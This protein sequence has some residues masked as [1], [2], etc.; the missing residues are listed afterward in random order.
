MLG[1]KG[2]KSSL[3][4]S[5]ELWIMQLPKLIFV[6]LGWWLRGWP[7]RC[8]MGSIENGGREY[9]WLATLYSGRKIV[10]ILRLTIGVEGRGWILMAENFIT[11]RFAVLCTSCASDANAVRFTGKEFEAYLNFAQLTGQSLKWYIDCIQTQLNFENLIFQAFQTPAVGKIL[12]PY[13]GLKRLGR[14]GWLLS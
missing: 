10:V 6:L 11:T 7:L 14:Q 1:E 3:R 2:A 9:H 13:Q 5:R 12:K 4:T 8:Q